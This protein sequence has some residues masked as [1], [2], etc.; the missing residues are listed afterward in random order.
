M[1]GLDGGFFVG[2]N[3]PANSQWDLLDDFETDIAAFT[4]Y[5]C[6]I[7]DD[8]ADIPDDYLTEITE[9]TD[10]PIAFTEMG[11]FRDGYPGWESS[12]EEQA[13]FIDRYF[14]LSEPINPVFTIWS[15]LYDQD[16]FEPFNSMGLLD[17][18]MTETAGWDA[19]R[20]H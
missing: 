10:Q 9:Y 4:L 15:F 5:P 12:S 18:N 20:S 8:P 13:T 1:K 2:V 19:W 3:D 16:T 11:W 7:Y 17:V 6:L 14:E